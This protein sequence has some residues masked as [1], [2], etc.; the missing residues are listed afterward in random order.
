[1]TYAK[2]DLER[3][4]RAD[5]AC[6]LANIREHLTWASNSSPGEILLSRDSMAAIVMRLINLERQAETLADGF[7]GVPR[8]SPGLL[9]T[10][11]QFVL[12][13]VA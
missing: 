8:R 11:Q 3:F 2:K 4:L 1:M 12:E 9:D 5:L 6:G 13:E 7:T 10:L